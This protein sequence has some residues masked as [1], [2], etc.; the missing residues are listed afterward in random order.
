MPPLNGI[1]LMCLYLLDVICL[2]VAF[3]CMY[4]LIVSVYQFRATL[5]SVQWLIPDSCEGVPVVAEVP[6][7]AGDDEALLG[8][9]LPKVGG[10]D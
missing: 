5:F 2:S 7:P 9:L 4:L 6:R 3:S 1:M 10:G 8:A